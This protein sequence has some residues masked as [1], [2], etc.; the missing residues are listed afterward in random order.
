L[1]QR[2]YEECIEAAVR[3]SSGKPDFSVKLSIGSCNDRFPG[4]RKLGG[5]HTYKSNISERSFDIKGPIPTK[6]EAEYIN[7]HDRG[8][9][10]TTM[11]VANIPPP[12]PGFQSLT[13]TP[14]P[15]WCQN[16]PAIERRRH[17]RHL[18]SSLADSGLERGLDLVLWI[19]QDRIGH[20][21]KRP[22]GRPLQGAEMKRAS[23]T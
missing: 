20:L 11:E 7:D 17:P 6:Q 15:G 8:C 5:G 9:Q 10:P 16:P 1:R 12:L 3:D 4:K 23:L 21:L 13:S 18:R 19:L 22:V 2:I 14:A